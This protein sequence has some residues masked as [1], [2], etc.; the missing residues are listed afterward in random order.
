ML[1]GPRSLP[2]PALAAGE[3]RSLRRPQQAAPGVANGRLA[4][5]HRGL[6]LIPDLGEPGEG[7]G[8]AARPQRRRYSNR[9]AGMEHLA[10]LYVDAGNFT[11]GG[12]GFM[13]L[14]ATFPK[15]GSTRGVSSTR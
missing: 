2:K 9:L 4:D 10:Q 5:D 13:K 8:R 1:T 7:A 15:V 12:F 3:D 6:A 14:P 11:F